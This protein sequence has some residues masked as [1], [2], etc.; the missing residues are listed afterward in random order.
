[1]NVQRNTVLCLRPVRGSAR[2]GNRCKKPTHD[3]AQRRRGV[4]LAPRAH[5]EFET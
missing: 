3:G 4:P 5:V 2:I 1:M